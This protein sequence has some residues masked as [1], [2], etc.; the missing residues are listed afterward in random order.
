MEIQILLFF[1]T[2][3]VL[4]LA[5]IIWTLAHRPSNEVSH[6][7][8]RLGAELKDVIY[9]R[10]GDVVSKMDGLIKLVDDKTHVMQMTN[11][12][13]LEKIRATVDEKLQTT[14]EPKIKESFGLVSE[15]LEQVHKGLGEMQNLATGVGDL[16]KVLNN[17]KTR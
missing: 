8:F 4:L 9:Q 15:R 10:L 3:N 6:D 12:Q 16:K 1:S 7:L 11:D 5:W 17:V 13:Q 2:I 14:L